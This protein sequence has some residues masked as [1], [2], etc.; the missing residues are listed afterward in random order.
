MISAF[1]PMSK[2]MRAL[3]L[4]TFISL[5]FLLAPIPALAQATFGSISG[6][7][8][9]ASGN[10]LANVSVDAGIEA[11]AYTD[12]NGN[13]IIRGLPFGQY[14]VG[15]PSQGRWASNDAG[16]VRQTKDTAISEASP[17]ATGINFVLVKGGSI[18]GKITDA[19]GNPLA[20]V[21]VDAGIEAEAY[22]DA[23][24]NYIIRG[25]PFGQYAVGAPGRGRVTSGNEYVRQ[26]R[27]ITLTLTSPDATGINFV[28]EYSNSKPNEPT[29]VL[30]V[31]IIAL[32]ISVALL[33]F[34]V[35]LIYRRNNQN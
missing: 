16:Y 5:V 8:T 13:Y 32:P 23:N 2:H 7:I 11:G 33:V 25:L 15:A 24:G 4:L 35:I 27:D 9:D 30:P 14:V 31:I 18:S 6:K 17:D 28:L 1:Y 3:S 10:P 29:S 26:T 34:V 19:N 22:T 21:S 20:N 12:A